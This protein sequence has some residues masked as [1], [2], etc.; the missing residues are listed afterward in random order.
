MTHMCASS[1]DKM[2]WQSGTIGVCGTAQLTITTKPEQEI[3][4]VVL[5]KRR[6]LISR[7]LDEG[8]RWLRCNL[9]EKMGSNDVQNDRVS[10]RALL[11]A[12]KAGPAAI[13]MES[14][15]KSI[16]DSNIA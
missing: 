6:I 7:V 14:I 2:T 9:T 15:Y 8:R 11:V 16:L 5:V 1:G 10:L 12:H 13:C 4:C 3:V